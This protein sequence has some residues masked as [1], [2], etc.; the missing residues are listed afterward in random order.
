MSQVLTKREN[1][2]N[3]KFKLFLSNTKWINTNIEELKKQYP[4][5]Y[6]A[7][8]Q[9]RVIQTDRDLTDLKR[10]L[11]ELNV[12]LDKVTIEF[13]KEKPLKLLV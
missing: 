7:V 4:D 5:R 8:C 3:H 1:E 10:R 11:R 9:K 13:I 12:D 2:L 6:I